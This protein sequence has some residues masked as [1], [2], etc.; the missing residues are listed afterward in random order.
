M[1]RVTVSLPAEL[2]DEIDRKLASQ[3]ES[4]SAVIRRLVE[5]ALREE[6]KRAEEERYIL[7]Y[8]EQPQTE[9]E[10]SWADVSVLNCPAEL[11]WE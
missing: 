11:P 10:L 2:A 4:R 9:E 3:G 8:R 7:A 1:N 5:A 6:E